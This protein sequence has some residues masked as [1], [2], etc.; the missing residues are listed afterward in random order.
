VSK[1]AL[2][3][4]TVTLARALAPEIRVNA[5]AGFIDTRWWKDAPDYKAVKAAASAMTP[6]GRVD[7]PQDVARDV[8]HLLTA[9][10]V[11]GHVLVCDGGIGLGALPQG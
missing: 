2:N 11:T 10:F 9:G 5:V 6:L 7:R 3:S 1:A 4:L 8:V